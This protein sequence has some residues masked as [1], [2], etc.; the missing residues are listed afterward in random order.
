M[1]G[2]SS[3]TDAWPKRMIRFLSSRRYFIHSIVALSILLLAVILQFI[4]AVQHSIQPLLRGCQ[5]PH[6]TIRTLSYDPLILHIENFITLQESKRLREIVPFYELS[7]VA[8]PNGTVLF[9]DRRTSS[10]AYLP[11][12]DLLVQ[13]L[14]KRAAEFQGYVGVENIESLQVTRYLEGQHFKHHYD[15]TPDPRQVNETTNRE[16]TIF[17]ILE[18]DCS[19]CGTEF[20]ALAINWTLEDNKWCRFVDC[21]STEALTIKPI[22]GSAIFWRNLHSD[23]SGDA[24]TMHAGQ[25]V[26]RGVKVGLNIWTRREI[27]WGLH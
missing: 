3:T 10:T 5:N 4:P 1:K 6:Y 26:E 25:K 21:N 27:T 8:L 22:P 20:P 13:C 9:S 11:G 23:G 18:A 7:K 2:E 15:W 16:T 17:A 12:D 24:R 14:K 19:M